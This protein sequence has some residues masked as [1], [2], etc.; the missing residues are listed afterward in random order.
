MLFAL[1]HLRTLRPIAIAH[2]TH[3]FHLLVDDMHIVGL[4]LDMLLVFCDYRKSLEH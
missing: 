3:V 2:P 4:A 1:V